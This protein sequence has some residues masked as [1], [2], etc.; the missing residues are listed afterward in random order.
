MIRKLI[1]IF[2]FLL[3][4]LVWL[5]PKE[6]D[7]LDR[8]A[9]DFVEIH[10]NVEINPTQLLELGTYSYNHHLI[11]TEFTYYFGEVSVKYYGFFTFI[12]FSES[13]IGEQ[14]PEDVIVYLPLD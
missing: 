5:A 11:Y 14:L 8:V 12:F 6:A 13:K 2:L 4:L 7:Y 1:F 3:I 9:T 10:E